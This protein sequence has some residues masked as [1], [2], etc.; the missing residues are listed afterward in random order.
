PIIE[1]NGVLRFGM[2][3]Q[4]LFPSLSADAILKPTLNWKLETNQPGKFDGEISYVSSGM[5]WQADYDLAVEDNPASSAAAKTDLL[6]LMGWVTMSNQAGKT[7][8]NANIKLMAGD[9]NKI[10]PRPMNGRAFDAVGGLVASKAMA[11]VVQEKAFD[12]FHLY[13]LQRATTL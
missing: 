7:F 6:D 8:E 10:Q 5:R 13:T 4:P 1:V 12:E 9:V 3:G 2:P 11:P